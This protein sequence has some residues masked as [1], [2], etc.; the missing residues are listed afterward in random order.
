MNIRAL[1]VVISLW[2]ATSAFG[3][4]APWYTL[5]RQINATI[6]D[7]PYVKV[8]EVQGAGNRLAIKL[9]CKD[10]RIAQGLAFTLK[11]QFSFGGVL[12]DIIVRGPDG[13][14]V[15]P[16]AI[17]A[18]TSVTDTRRYLRMALWG[19]R[20]IVSITTGSSWMAGP[21]VLVETRARV[22]QFWNDDLS[23][24]NGYVHEVA[25]EAFD[26]LLADG[27]KLQFFTSIRYQ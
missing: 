16:P 4:S 22:V 19:N 17:P 9:K 7:S 25:A 20:N 3:L 13:V 24:P 1:V 2:V 18:Q 10:A 27:L 6:G 5:Q 11:P 14:P 12:V 21:L 26:G 23:D 8:G 15:R